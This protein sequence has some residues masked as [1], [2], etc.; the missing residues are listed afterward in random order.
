MFHF[1]DKL[2]VYAG[3]DPYTGTGTVFSD[4]FSFSLTTGLWKKEQ[5]FTELKDGAGTLL[6]RAL[7]MY[8]SDAVIFSGGCNTVTQECAAFGSTKSILIEQPSAHFTAGLVDDDE[9]AGRMGHSLVQLGDSV[10]AFGGCS[11]GK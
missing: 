8:N 2:Y 11:F 1:A 4:F 10:I 5:G 7:R 3:A 6:G 9:Y